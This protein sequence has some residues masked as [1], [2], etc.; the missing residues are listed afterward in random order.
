M[1]LSPEEDRVQSMIQ[2]VVL[3]HY[4]PSPLH[5]LT[6]AA[7]PRSSPTSIRGGRSTRSRIKRTSNLAESVRKARRGSKVSIDD[8]I[9]GENGDVMDLDAQENLV[10]FGTSGTG[11][12]RR[13][14]RKR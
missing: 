7:E 11:N 10:G 4:I 9:D 13:S 6:M 1:S 8:S 5:L 12:T 3:L 2:T 14:G